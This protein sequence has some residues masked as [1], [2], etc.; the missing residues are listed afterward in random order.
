M[1]KYGFGIDIGGTTCKIGLFETTGQ[2]VEKWEITTNTTE[3]GKHIL[4]NVAD[5]LNKKMKEKGIAREEI[6]G[7][8]IGVPGPVRGDGSVSTCVNLGWK[9]MHVPKEMEVLMEGITVKA[10]NDANVAALGEMWQGGGKGY[11]NVVMVTLGTGVGGGIIINERIVAGTNGAGGEIGHITVNRQESIPCNCGRKGCLEQYASATGIARLARECLSKEHAPSSLD[12]IELEKVIAK[13]VFDAYKTG[14]TLAKE[15]IEK[16][17]DI[18]GNALANIACVVDP[19]VIVIGGG[20][21]KA[22][23]VLLDVVQKHFK[24]VAFSSCAETKFALASLGN[25]AGMYGCVKLIIGEE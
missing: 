3:C 5:S 21:S 7:I 20:V 17:A 18:L 14:D 25:D 6:E 16:F 12:S 19:E 8:G 22:G 1:K 23:E 15:M 9:N 2:I 10:G 24:E 11:E 4:S 13:D